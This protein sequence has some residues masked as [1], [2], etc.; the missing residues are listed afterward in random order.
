[1]AFEDLGS[2]DQRELIALRRMLYRAVKELDYARSAEVLSMVSSAE[3]NDV[4][5]FG[6][7]LLGVADLSEEELPVRL[8][9]A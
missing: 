1:M 9:R 3:G 4:I 8:E 6:M 5:E 2:D 7:K